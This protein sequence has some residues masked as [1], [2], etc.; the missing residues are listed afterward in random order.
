MQPDLESRLEH[1]PAVQRV[2]HSASSCAIEARRA[3]SAPPSSKLL[4]DMK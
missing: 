2:S 4:P 3:L 1:T